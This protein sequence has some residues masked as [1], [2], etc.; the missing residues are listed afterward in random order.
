MAAFAHLRR[1]ERLGL[2]VAVLAHVALVAG[3][4]VEA[5]RA[6]PVI[7]PAERMTVS[8]AEDVGPQSTTTDLSDSAQ[9]AVAP[10]L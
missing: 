3:L 1:E 8:L 5:R 10:V 4:I 9:A 6:P 7:P 2:A